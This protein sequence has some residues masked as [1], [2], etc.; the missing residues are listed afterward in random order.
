MERVLKKF[1]F[2]VSPQLVLT[3]AETRTLERA[4]GIIERMREYVEPESSDDYILAGAEHGIRDILRNLPLSL[5][6]LEE[7]EEE[8]S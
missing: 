4:M 6:E 2:Y 7:K 1:V 5:D 8:V 3:E